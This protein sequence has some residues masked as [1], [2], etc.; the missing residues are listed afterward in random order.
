MIR[1]LLFFITLI[2]LSSC[3]TI[4]RFEE[5]DEEVL[6]TGKFIINK[7]EKLTN[8]DGSQRWV[9]VTKIPR[10]DHEG[11]II[12]TMGIS[13][14]VTEWKRLEELHKSEEIS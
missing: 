9:S 7:I 11:N 8:A 2:V 1:I 5:D 12:G 4:S 3:G 14:D 6:K 13:R 10:F